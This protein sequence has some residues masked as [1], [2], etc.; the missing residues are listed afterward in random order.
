VA[1]SKLKFEAVKTIEDFEAFVAQPENADRRFELING[2]VLEKMPTQLH[3]WIVLF[4][5]RLLLNY[6]DLNPIGI[7]YADARYQLSDDEENSRIPDLSFVRDELG[8]M[9]EEGAAPYMPDL[10]IEIQSP[11]DDPK[12]M[13]DKADYYLAN[14]SRMVWLIFT[15]KR[16]RRI[17]V[18]RSD[19]PMQTL[20]MDDTLN[21]GDVLP[22]FSVAVKSLFERSTGGKK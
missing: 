5:G 8:P 20:N 22:G 15:R 13:R 18:Y 11:D 16:S 21:G 3:G 14:G 7:S 17:E 2:R 6:L 9:I 12:Q 19:Q 1:I 4:L 10:A